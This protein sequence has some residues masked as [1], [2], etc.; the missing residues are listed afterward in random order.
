[1]SLPPA[2]ER[3]IRP[4]NATDDYQESNQGSG[5]P[6]AMATLPPRRLFHTGRDREE[7]SRRAGRQWQPC[8]CIVQIVR[9][10][11]WARAIPESVN[12]YDRYWHGGGCTVAGSSAK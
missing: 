7:A 2:Y 10:V 6:E 3:N 1:M 11:P 9:I 12:G 8:A 4:E 5:A